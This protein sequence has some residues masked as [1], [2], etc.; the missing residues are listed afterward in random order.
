MEKSFHIWIH[1]SSSPLSNGENRSALRLSVRKLFKEYSPAF[2]FK[3]GSSSFFLNRYGILKYPVSDFVM[4]RICSH[5]S[6]FETK[7][8]ELILQLYI[9]WFCCTDSISKVIKF[10]RNTEGFPLNQVT[11]MVRIRSLMSHDTLSVSPLQDIQET[12]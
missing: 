1:A 7:Q 8:N 6:S 2:Y 10:L 11:Q 12:I 4:F 5:S 3:M 9:I